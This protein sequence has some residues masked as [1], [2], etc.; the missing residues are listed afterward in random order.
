M[1]PRTSCPLS[2]WTLNM[3][4]GRASTISPSISIFSSLGT[5][6]DA[7]DR[8]DVHR[9]G[10]LVARLFLV[11]DL[12]VLG[13][14][15]EALPVDARV[16]DEEVTIAVVRRDESVALLVV[17]PLDGSGRHVP[18]PSCLCPVGPS[19]R[20]PYHGTCMFQLRRLSRP[21]QARTL[22]A[23]GGR[24]P[25]ATAQLAGDLL[26][27]GLLRRL[28]SHREPERIVLVARNHMHVH[29]EDRL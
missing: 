6:C 13:E 18:A 25:S 4:F 16:V 8:A 27:L 2:S 3:V 5:A 9:L 7:L 20:I 26:E 17:E 22:P 21:F 29:V 19:V 11:L 1:W 15:L 24:S 23:W 14:R 10:A 28:R 12:R